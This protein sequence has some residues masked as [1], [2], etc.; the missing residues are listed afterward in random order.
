[1]QKLVAKDPAIHLNTACAMVVDQFDQNSPVRLTL[2][3]RLRKKF[4]YSQT[5]RHEKTHGNKVL[6]KSQEIGV[7]GTIKAYDRSGRALILKDLL[8]AIR[9]TF[10]LGEQWSG[11]S[12]WSYFQERHPE[13]T[14]Q[15]KELI[16]ASRFDAQTRDRVIKFLDDLELVESATLYPADSRYNVDETII[17]ISPK[18]VPGKGLSADV[19]NSGVR[20]T[21]VGSAIGSM[22]C[23]VRADGF[24]EL[25][26]MCL[27]LLRNKED[28]GVF[29][30]RLL[31]EIRNT[32]GNFPIFYAFNATGMMNSTLW[33]ESLKA[34]QKIRKNQFPGKESI[35]FCDNLHCHRDL[36]AL[37]FA[38]PN[39]IE[40]FY[41]PPNTSKWL[42][43]LDQHIFH[44]FKQ[45]LLRG[46]RS[47]S[48]T[49]RTN[50]QWKNNVMNQVMEALPY[51][52][53]QVSITASWEKTGLSPYSRKTILKN[54]SVNLPLAGE[55]RSDE[56]AADK[57]A[58][59]L[60]LDLMAQEHLVAQNS[61]LEDE[62]LDVEVPANCI[63]SG[64]QVLEIQ[65]QKRAD[66]E[67]HDEEKFVE[68]LEAEEAKRVKEAQ[69]SED[70]RK[71]LAESEQAKKDKELE[72]ERRELGYRCRG[73]SKQKKGITKEWTSCTVCNAFSVCSECGAEGGSK[74]IL[75]Q[76]GKRCRGQMLQYENQ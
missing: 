17:G 73:C 4:C 31:K 68:A 55:K 48:S 75:G 35:L 6:S 49:R 38:I 14:Y 19:E 63:F 59:K 53:T 23:F 8:D 74:S 71:R 24:P 52:F 30:G 42:Q 60:C 62:E 32:R 26:I 33:L 76:H 22:T 66:Q 39:G 20:Q 1:V 13:A 46:I 3:D 57:A 64:S 54:M 67:K 51:A 37:E 56:S 25:A 65:K 16:S 61:N 47:C 12:W 7:L 15:K 5:I 70:R 72:K 18:K 44:L 2:I 10:K 34:F 29:K 28:T 69:A 45:K 43:P 50:E 36:A 9:S 21:H 11:W 41:L 40:V 58:R 27:K